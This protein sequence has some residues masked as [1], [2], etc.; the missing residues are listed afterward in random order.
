MPMLAIIMFNVFCR[1]SLQ[2]QVSEPERSQCSR[3]LEQNLVAKQSE[4]QG[5]NPVKLPGLP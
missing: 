3:R 4:R 2:L 5:L 1:S